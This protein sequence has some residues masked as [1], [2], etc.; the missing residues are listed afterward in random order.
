[1]IKK[2]AFHKWLGKDESDPITEEDIQ[3]GLSSTDPHVQKMALFAKNM[4]NGL[5]ECAL[6]E[7][8]T[9]LK[10]TDLYEEFRNPKIPKSDQIA[11]DI[12]VAH[13]VQD[14]L[15]YARHNLPV[16]T[17]PLKTLIENKP[18]FKLPGDSDEPDNSEEFRRR[19]SG[20]SLRDYIDGKKYPPI[21]VIKKE[22]GEFLVYDGRH[23]VVSFVRLL[24]MANKNPLI[25]GIKGFIMDERLLD[26]IPSIATKNDREIAKGLW[27]NGN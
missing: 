7:I 20:L 26:K 12:Q 16:V 11:G 5:K 6:K 19:V 23:R 4:K 22:N 25:Y 9:L 8:V 24:Q 3:T 1:M 14:L 10:E 18:P 2:G 13:D 17:V 21:L 27:G 15:D